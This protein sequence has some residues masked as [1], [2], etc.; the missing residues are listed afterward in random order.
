MRSFKNV[1]AGT[2]LAA[3]ASLGVATAL[4]VKATPSPGEDWAYATNAETQPCVPQVSV[5]D[6]VV[7][8]TIRVQVSRGNTCPISNNIFL[9]IQDD[10]RHQPLRI[11]GTRENFLSSTWIFR[12]GDARPGRYRVMGLNPMPGG[13]GDDEYISAYHLGIDQVITIGSVE[14]AQVSTQQPQQPVSPPPQ[15]AVPLQQVVVLDSESMRELRNFN[16]WSRNF[17]QWMRWFQVNVW[18]QL[19][20]L[21]RAIEGIK[22]S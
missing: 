1:L 22:N 20:P 3:T 4:P 15:V 10:G 5:S 12:P 18:P 14:M 13:I 9:F 2:V 19:Q 8:N 6:N 17:D 21:I 16:H 11:P 7:D